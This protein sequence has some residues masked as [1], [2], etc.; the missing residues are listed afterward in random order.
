MRIQ[1]FQAQ[2]VGGMVS[3]SNF[4]SSY[5]DNIR[6][7]VVPPTQLTISIPNYYVSSSPTSIQVDYSTLALQ[8]TNTYSKRIWD[9]HVHGVLKKDVSSA[10]MDIIFYPYDTEN[11]ALEFLTTIGFEGAMSGT[12]LVR[13]SGH[14]YDVSDYWTYVYN[15][16]QRMLTLAFQNS[17]SNPV[18]VSVDRLFDIY[19]NIA[20]VILTSCQSGSVPY[21]PDNIKNTYCVHNSSSTGA[22]GGFAVSGDV[23]YR[24]YGQN[25][26]VTPSFA[27]SRNKL[28]LTLTRADPSLPE[29]SLGTF[30]GPIFAV[31]YVGGP[32]S[33]NSY[34]TFVNQTTSRVCVWIDPTIPEGSSTPYMPSHV[35]VDP[36]K[37]TVAL[38]SP[39]QT[40]FKYFDGDFASCQL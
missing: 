32:M 9:G 37:N 7:A 38:L 28:V 10:S 16:D 31:N 33:T 35:F 23:V 3:V 40:Y 6:E 14:V 39:F 24:D 30:F 19:F 13:S 17:I 34:I 11:D 8:P 1:T 15:G 4:V 12:F 27:G 25:Y 18:D 26:R 21:P 20:N 5:E 29:H 36:G 22:F 2:S